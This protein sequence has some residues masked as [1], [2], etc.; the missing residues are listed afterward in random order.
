MEPSLTEI[1]QRAINEH[2]NGNFQK[3]ENLYRT[4]LNIDPKHP[5]ANH[6][7]GILAVSFNKT[8]KALPFFKVAIEIDP[9]L[10][11]FYLSYV[12]AL[13][14]LNKF[15][16]AVVVIERGKKNGL[17]TN[18]FNDYLNIIDEKNKSIEI[19]KPKEVKA[20]KKEL[21]KLLNY[22]KNQ[23]LSKAI[24][25]AKSNT[26]KFPKDVFSWKILGEI[27]YSQNKFSEAAEVFENAIKLS[28]DDVS[29]LNNLSNTLKMLGRFEDAELNCRKAIKLKPTDVGLYNNLG[30]ILID[31]NKMDEAE[32]IFRKALEIDPKNSNTYNNLSIILI[33]LGRLHEAED[34]CERSIKIDKKNPQLFNNYGIVLQNKGKFKEAII[35]YKKAISLKPDF[36]LANRNIGTLYYDIKDYENAVIAFENSNEMDC[37]SYLLKCYYFL[38]DKENFCKLLEI[39]ESKGEINATI[40]SFSARAK[41]KFAIQKKNVFVSEPF[42][43]VLN[44]NLSDV[45]D[46]DSIFIQTAK[47]IL[48]KNKVSYRFQNLLTNGS[49]TAGDLFQDKSQVIKN[50]KEILIKEIE[51][52]RKRFENSKEGFIRNWPNKYQIRGWLINM[53][54]GGKLDPHMHENGWISGAIYINV[55][56]KKEKNS[57]NFVVCIDDNQKNNHQIINVE[58]GSLV[59]FPSSL[60]HYTIPFESNEKRIVLAFDVIPIK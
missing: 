33:N 37:G 13:L 57:G 2:K 42:N 53:N 30:L 34:V 46:F 52:Y 15:D 11:Q 59:F 4:I 50:I 17:S 39:M 14:K 23:K 54:T 48:E 9:K 18:I 26:K 36:S 12:E 27:L 45:Y 51:D 24:K 38:G 40:G 25:L 35:N 3:A 43:Y 10:E 58:T 47:D 31:L 28:P 56:P 6:N 29:I 20:P 22:Y 1:L 16:E 49:Q 41:N 5:H 7:L 60:L 8:D 44:L 21:N 32:E 55:P 19:K